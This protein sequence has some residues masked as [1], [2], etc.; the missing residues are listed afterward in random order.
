MVIACLNS[1]YRVWVHASA[2]AHHSLTGLF[3]SVLDFTDHIFFHHASTD[4]TWVFKAVVLTNAFKKKVYLLIGITFKRD[5]VGLFLWM[6]FKTASRLEPLWGG[7]LIF[8][9]KFSEIPGTHF[10]DLRRMKGWVD[11]GAT[12]WFWT[13]DPFV[14][15]DQVLL[16]YLPGL[17]P[18]WEKLLPSKTLR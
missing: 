18:N 16:L 5:F 17:L 6:G 11:L 4:N 12:Q 9:T 10:I 2:I 3:S 15:A 8:T 13:Q 14:S 1:Y 7:S